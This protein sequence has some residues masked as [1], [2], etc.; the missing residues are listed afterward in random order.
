MYTVEYSKTAQ[1]QIRKLDKTLQR[2]I[3]AWIDKHPEG[4]DNPRRHGKGLTGNRAREWRYRIGDYRLIADIQ[5]DKM[6]ILA[7]ELVHRRQI[8][9]QLIKIPQQ[10]ICTYLALSG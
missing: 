1:R 6:I 4:T 3:I 5:D 10:N 7:L 9:K 2:L 8:Y